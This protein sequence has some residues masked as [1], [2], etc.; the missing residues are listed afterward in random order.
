MSDNKHGISVLMAVCA[1]DEKDLFERALVSIWDSQTRRPDQIVLVQD[2]VISP[3]VYRVIE[4][5]KGRCDVC[6]HHI[7]LE[8]NMGLAFALNSGIE[9]CNFNYI[10]RMDSD[11]YSYPE[12]F[13]MQFDFLEA[14]PEIAVVGTFVE[15]DNGIDENLVRRLPTKHEDLV[16]FS[17]KRNPLSH[18]SVMMRRSSVSDAGG[19]PALRKCQDFALWG[20]MM[21]QGYRFANIDRVLVKMTAGNEMMA[22]RGLKYW[23]NEIKL[24][25]YLYSIGFISRYRFWKNTL[26][27]STV[28]I[29]PIFVR[30]LMYKHFR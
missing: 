27:R 13:S 2:G 5:W 19:Y 22:R 10:A 11:D 12:R 3:D 26:G 15:E 25:R 14:S 28:R 29:P 18:P 17:Q 9:H 16:K 4:K 24:F 23:I 21:S 6:L 30:K 7:V 8:K 20:K 1:S